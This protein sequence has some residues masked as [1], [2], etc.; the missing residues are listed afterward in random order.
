MIRLW[1]KHLVDLK[2]GIFHLIKNIFDGS[3]KAK[4]KIIPAFK[5]ILNNYQHQ[6]RDVL[7]IVMSHLCLVSGLYSIWLDLTV[8]FLLT[9]VIPH[10]TGNVSLP[11]LLVEILS[12][13][14]VRLSHILQSKLTLIIVIATL[15]R[16][17]LLNLCVPHLS[18]VFIFIVFNN[19]ILNKHAIDYLEDKRYDIFEGLETYFV[20][21]A[22]TSVHVLLSLFFII[23][24]LT[25][26]QLQIVILLIIYIN[27]YHCSRKLVLTVL[28]DGFSHW[29]VLARF[30][31]ATADELIRL[32]DV[33]AICLMTMTYARK[34]V[35]NHYFHG[36]CLR[37]VI[38]KSRTCPICTTVIFKK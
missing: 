18:C 4:D 1:M 17:Y 13:R 7:F 3:M 25:I 16:H 19:N 34:T 38:A 35:C 12:E 9:H 36:Y 2:I 10:P 15:S 28:S 23:W 22:S 11:H 32:D 20:T 6:V 5:E 37:G 21:L 31:R 30:P 24:T 26:S 8:Y 33:C 27:V 14:Y 29:S